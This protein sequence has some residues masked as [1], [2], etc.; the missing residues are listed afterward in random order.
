MTPDYFQ[1]PTPVWTANGKNSVKIGR[2]GMILALI[3]KQ[4]CA[5]TITGA[6]NIA[7][8]IKR[9]DDLAALSHIRVFGN[10]GLPLIDLDGPDLFWL[11]WL[12]GSGSMPARVNSTL[13]DGATANP[14]LTTQLEIPLTS[15]RCL[16]PFDSALDST[17]YTDL[18]A[19]LTF[20]DYTSI[21]GSAT[22]WTTTP[23]YELYTCEVPPHDH[24]YL[25]KRVI[26]LT[27]TFSASGTQ[28]I[29]LDQGPEYRRFIINTQN[30]GNDATGMF[31][32]ARLIS[33][34]RIKWNLSESVM[35]DVLKSRYGIRFGDAVR[36]N[37]V[38]NQD[39][40]Y[41]AEQVYYD[42]LLTEA[43][44]TERIATNYLEFDITQ[45]CTVNVLVEVLED[46][47]RPQYG[48]QLAAAA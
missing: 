29:N 24:P 2:G 5:P 12:G 15:T 3:L 48:G 47:R 25:R 21:S 44:D 16:K 41:L 34:G 31:S 19:E 13:A 42:G 27:Q 39:A 9:G 46:L 43:L 7:A 20:G 23:S 30:A 6:N 10:D 36:K 32:R 11:N 45:A 22:G 8:N 1:Q 14:T 40:W 28:R 35:R 17:R 33:G 18:T 26:K 38:E 4:T 37:T